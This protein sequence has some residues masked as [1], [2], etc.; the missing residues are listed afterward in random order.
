MS[1]V[2]ALCLLLLAGC[3]TSGDISNPLSRKVTW[4][5]YLEGDDIRAACGPAAP[6]RYRLIYNGN[7]EEQLRIYD[8][9]DGAPGRLTQRVV[10]G[11]GLASWTLGDPFAPWSGQATQVDLQPQKAR[12]LIAALA[13]AGAFGRPAE[14]LELESRSFFWTLAACHE[15]RYHFTAWLEASRPRFVEPI[16]AVDATG[17][18]FNAP[19]PVA[20]RFYGDDP[21][22]DFRLRVGSNGLWGVP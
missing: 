2:V 8:L 13:E 10:G 15:G 21:R 20:P 3:S 22:P 12:E 5:S 19:H 11:G 6:A 18:T 16:L 14:G 9:G 7:Y 17:T 4:F 1:R